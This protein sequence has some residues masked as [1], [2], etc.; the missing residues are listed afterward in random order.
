[1][2]SLICLPTG[3]GACG[4]RGWVWLIGLAIAPIAMRTGF[5]PIA[6]P[7]TNKKPTMADKSR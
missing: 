6:E 7:L 5:F 2:L 4:M 3:F 1:M